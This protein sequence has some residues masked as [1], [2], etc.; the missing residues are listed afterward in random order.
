MP[1]RRVGRLLW[2]PT[3]ATIA[4]LTACHSDHKSSKD[5]ESAPNHRA[6]TSHT[7]PSTETPPS[8]V[9]TTAPP[10]SE[11]TIEPAWW[12]PAKGL[13]WQWQLDG[14][15]DMSVDAEVYDV[16]LFE[17]PASTVQTLHEQGRKAIC[18]FSAGSWEPYRPDSDAFPASVKGGSVQGWPDERWL[19]IR[20]LDVLRPLLASRLDLC[21]ERGFD[22]VE[23]DWLDGYQADTGFPLTAA[24][25]LAFNRMLADM[26]HER[27]LAIGLKNDLDQV[28]DLADL[29]DFAVVEQCA[30]YGECEALIPFLDRNKPVFHAEYDLTVPE[31]CAESRRLG[32]SSIRKRIELGPW[33]ETC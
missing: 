29:Y 4:A 22:G 23:P 20:Q 32:L 14:H 19:D 8:S 11:P 24:D 6:T 33:R 13:T 1:L 17:T 31:F 27:H 28:K 26:A 16:D 9:D 3:L 15:V 5:E 30:E 18:Y 2:W 25:Q 10:P 7:E 12:R 21:A